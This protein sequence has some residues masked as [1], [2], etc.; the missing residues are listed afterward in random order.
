L[1]TGRI[2]LFVLVMM[3][4]AGCAE[5]PLELDE[6]GR[7]TLCLPAGEQ[8]WVPLHTELAYTE[9]ARETGLSDRERLPRREGMLFLYPEPQPEDNRFW[10]HQTP[11]PLDIAFL[12]TGGTILNSFSMRPCVTDDPDSCNRHHAGVEHQAVLEVNK[13]LLEALG[14]SEGDQL[15]LGS[16]EGQDQCDDPSPFAPSLFERAH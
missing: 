10:M 9:E 5:R 4:S 1:S 6:R 2:G 12:D 13:G 16:V 7:A 3:M 11:M 8:Q 15:R 14:V